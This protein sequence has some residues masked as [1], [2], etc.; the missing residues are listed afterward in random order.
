V[1]AET[2]PIHKVFDIQVPGNWDSF[3]APSATEFRECRD[4]GIFP[5]AW[6]TNSTPD[7]A[8]IQISDVV[9]EWSF[10]AMFHVTVWFG[11]IGN[12]VLVR[13]PVSLAFFLTQTLPGLKPFMKEYEIHE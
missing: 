4:D 11:G 5:V 12:S 3:H 13:D 8:S 7:S 9:S 1:A 10:E 2:L 6:H